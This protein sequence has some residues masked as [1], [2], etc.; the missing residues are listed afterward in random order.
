MS[1]KN[2][3]FITIFVAL[4]LFAQIS[5]SDKK[6]D[7]K[8][9]DFSDANQLKQFAKSIAGDQFKYATYENFDSDTIKEIVIGREIETGDEWGI[10]FSFYSTKQNRQEVYTTILLEG[11]FNGASVMPMKVAGKDHQLLYYN[12]GDFFLG[13]GGGEI[14]TYVIDYVDKKVHA[15]KLFVERS[16]E[17]KLQIL[18]DGQEETIENYFITFYKK[19]Y[20]ELSII[21]NNSEAKNEQRN[22]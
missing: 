9:I 3:F 19:E 7:I 4:I 18:T 16:G 1:F 5:C 14:F 15:A 8:Q 6:D 11:S 22:Q 10:K 20:P 12:S 21:T 13:S 17:A 2:N